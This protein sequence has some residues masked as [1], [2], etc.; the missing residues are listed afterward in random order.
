MDTK[1]LIMDATIQAF[2]RKGIKFTMDDIAKEL[3]I[4]K[5]TIYTLF[6]TKENLFL[7]TV[8]YC[9][10]QIHQSEQHILEDSSLT[11]LEK[12]EKMLVVLPE[13][14]QNIDWRTI[15]C[16]IF[17]DQGSNVPCIGRRILITVPPGKSKIRSLNPFTLSH[18]SC[19]VC[20][21]SHT[22]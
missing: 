1:E 2:N 6:Q 16:G 21:L 20:K 9:F 12:L 11:T 10:N 15:V 14:Y 17:L 22:L 13:R 5:K 8:D 3:H 4:S 19:S 18:L 7:S